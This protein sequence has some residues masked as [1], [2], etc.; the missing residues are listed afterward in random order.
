MSNLDERLQRVK[1]LCYPPANLIGGKLSFTG[2]VKVQSDA[3]YSSKSS[4]PSHY[5][6]VDIFVSP[7]K[8]GVSFVLSNYIQLPNPL[9]GGRYV[10]GTC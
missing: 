3:H 9:E 2:V 10:H 5:R 8:L 7:H 6:S 4:F 1:L